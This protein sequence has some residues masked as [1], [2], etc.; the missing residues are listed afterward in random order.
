MFFMHKI[1]APL[2]QTVLFTKFFEIKQ[3]DTATKLTIGITFLKG[4]KFIY[5]L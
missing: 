5:K 2:K 3:D 1:T 4:T